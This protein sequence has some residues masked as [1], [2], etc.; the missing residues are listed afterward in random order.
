[1]ASRSKPPAPINMMF[2]LDIRGSVPE[3]YESQI[4]VI[5]RSHKV[6][7][8]QSPVKLANFIEELFLFKG[9]LLR[10]ARKDG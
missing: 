3:E 9:R 8:K 6:A 7:T 4:N 10:S 1:M 2:L 5:A